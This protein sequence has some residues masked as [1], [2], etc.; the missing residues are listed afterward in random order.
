MSA[1]GS[2]EEARRRWLASI[3]AVEDGTAAPSFGFIFFPSA[4]GGQF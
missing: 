4:G 1:L 2:G 3:E